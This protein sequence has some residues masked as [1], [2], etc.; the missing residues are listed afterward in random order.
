MLTRRRQ[1]SNH[2]GVDVASVSQSAQFAP[3]DAAYAWLNTTPATVVYRPATTFFN[4][5]TVR[6]LLPSHLG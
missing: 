1:I 3:F 5:Y 2:N 6:P 4:P